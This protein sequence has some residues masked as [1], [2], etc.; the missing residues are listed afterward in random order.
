MSNDKM[1]KHSYDTEVLKKKKLKAYNMT[2][3]KI[4]QNNNYN[5]NTI[6]I[7]HGDGLYNRLD[8]SSRSKND[9]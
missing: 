6:T 5:N 1:F 9:R 3:Q 7:M 2:V 4:K 8:C